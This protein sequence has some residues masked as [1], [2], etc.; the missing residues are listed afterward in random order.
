[1]SSKNIENKKLDEQKEER[2]IETNPKEKIIDLTEDKK[3]EL[4]AIL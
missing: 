4:M 1:M 3:Q 2:K